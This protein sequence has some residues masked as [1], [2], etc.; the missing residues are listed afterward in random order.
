[1]TQIDASHFDANTASLS[2]SRFRV[3]DLTPLVFRTHDGGRTWTRITR[4]MADNAPVNVVRE[5][6]RARGLLFAGTERAVY[7]SFNDGDDWQP[8]SLN[9]PHTSVRIDLAT[10]YD[11]VEGADRAP[12]TQAIKAVDALEQRLIKLVGRR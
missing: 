9:L 6:P 1:M 5:D 7:V 4:G 8:L 12:T 3:D 10:A 2:V 11:V